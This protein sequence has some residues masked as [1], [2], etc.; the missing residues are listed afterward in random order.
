MIDSKE[1]ALLLAL[2]ENGLHRG[3]THA[4]DSTNTMCFICGVCL[5]H[6]ILLNV[7]IKD[8][9]VFSKTFKA[10]EYYRP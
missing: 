5:I 9:N 2:S 6:V 3:Q 8:F 10:H 7:L 1:I 4:Q